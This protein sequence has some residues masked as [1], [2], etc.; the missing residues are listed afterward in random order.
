MIGSSNKRLILL[1]VIAITAGLLG[2][3][4][5]KS[6]KGRQV[7]ATYTCGDSTC[8]RLTAAGAQPDTLAIEAGTFVRFNSADGQKHSLSL[9]RGGE[10]HGHNGPFSSGDFA[11][12]EAWKVQ[13]KDK[14]TYLFHDHYNPKINVLIVVYE[15]DG[16]NTIR[17]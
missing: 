16:D 7:A 6:L 1:A 2:F 4:G 11:A 17:R 3:M 10:E 9:G 15:P 12:D 8:V 5:T 13:F 14:G